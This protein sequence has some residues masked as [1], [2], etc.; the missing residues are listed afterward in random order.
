V[1]NIELLFAGMTRA[2]L[3]DWSPRPGHLLDPT[4]DWLAH[5]STDVSRLL[6]TEGF[7]TFF[8]QATPIDAIEE[9]A[10][11]RP[12]RRPRTG[13]RRSRISWV[14][15]WNQA[16]FYVPGWRRQ[17]SNDCCWRIPSS[18]PAR[19]ISTRGPLYTTRATPPCLRPLTST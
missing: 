19:R 3:L 18:R 17:R 7:I 16:R 1:S 5:E 13:A 14:F 9:A 12:S 10:S 15:S 8:R 11:A 2:T 4:M 6:E